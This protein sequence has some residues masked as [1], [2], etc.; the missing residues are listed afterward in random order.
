[1][2]TQNCSAEQRRILNLIWASAGEYGFDPLFM[3]FGTDKKPDYY[4]NCMVGFVHKWYGDQMV[5]DLFARWEGDVRQNT[6]DDLAWLALENAAY[7][8]ELAVRPVLRELRQEHA[9]AFFAQEYLLSRQEWMAKNQLVYS[10]QNARWKA[11]LNKHSPVLTPR[12]KELSQA[13]LCSGLLT[14]SQLS[15]EILAI[16]KKFLL[17]DGS[18]RESGKLQKYIREKWISGISSAAPKKMVRTDSLKISRSQ[19]GSQQEEMIPVTF[20]RGQIR[21]VS[22]ESSRKDGLYIARCF[23]RSLY[24]SAELALIDQDLCTGNHFG[25]H[26][27]FTDGSP[28]PGVDQ[29]A[30]SRRLTEQA[31]QQEKRNREYFHAHM[32]L[33]QNAVRRLSQQ[34]RN[35]VLVHQQTDEELS[36]RGRLDAGRVWRESVLQDDRVF[37]RRE[38]EPRPSFT[39]D[40]LLDGSASRLRNQEVIAAQ[41]YILSESLCRCGI[42]VRVS[43]FCSLRS[44]TVLRILKDYGDK[45]GQQ[46]IFRYFAAG[47]NRDGLALRGIGKL[48]QNHKARKH[49]PWLTP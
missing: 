11:V 41:G 28:A 40:L 10:M 29:D 9:S 47:W 17:F 36:R 8:K 21:M 45:H 1:M 20:A 48:L 19:A 3:A 27:W 44:Y 7:E 31:L 33:H 12:E 43:S 22:R 46:N 38:E 49:I 26:L 34:I 42:D 18:V 16:M 15:S 6:M 37:T 14:S 13:L 5:R 23:G 39:V 4:M 30:E 32:D 35:C 24:S 2:M 25:C